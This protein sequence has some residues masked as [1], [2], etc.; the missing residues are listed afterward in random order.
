MLIDNEKAPQQMHNVSQNPAYAEVMKELTEKYN[1]VR[2]LYRVSADW[3]GSRNR[4][5]DYLPSW[6]PGEGD[7]IKM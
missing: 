6:G 7:R 4:T 3:P 2:A 5:P 1:A